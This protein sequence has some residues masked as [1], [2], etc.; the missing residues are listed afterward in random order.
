MTQI[1]E[2]QELS[3]KMNQVPIKQINVK[4]DLKFT[5]LFRIRLWVGLELL[6]L[7]SH[8]WDCNI[9]VDLVDDPS[10]LVEVKR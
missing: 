1:S 7:L 8:V 5:R 6:W 9:D 3:L 4:V 2:E 10:R